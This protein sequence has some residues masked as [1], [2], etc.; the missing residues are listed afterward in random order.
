MKYTYGMC[1]EF[2]KMTLL[3]KNKTIFVENYQIL[4]LCLWLLND[5]RVVL[6]A[7]KKICKKNSAILGIFMRI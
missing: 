4:V 7:K 3:K 1:D 2:V 6:L 5:S